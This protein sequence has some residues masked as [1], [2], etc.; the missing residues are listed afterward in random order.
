MVNQRALIQPALATF[1]FV[2]SPALGH[3]ED[4]TNQGQG[5]LIV[6]LYRSLRTASLRGMTQPLLNS[7]V[8]GME[9]IL[10]V[11]VGGKPAQYY[12]WQLFRARKLIQ[13]G[14]L[15]AGGQA[16]DVAVDLIG[17]LT[18]DLS[19]FKSIKL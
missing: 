11:L 8:M 1:T 17:G 5:E 7:A 4:I 18:Y 9:T 2:S 14:T 10:E 12:R 13:R 3:H 15:N 16:G 19:L 6:R